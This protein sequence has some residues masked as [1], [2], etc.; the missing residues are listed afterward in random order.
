MGLIWIPGSR[1]QLIRHQARA[2]RSTSNITWAGLVWAHAWLGPENPCNWGLQFL[3]RVPK[4]APRYPNRAT[5]V[6]F[7]RIFLNKQHCMSYKLLY[8]TIYF[9]C[10]KSVSC[11]S[12]SVCLYSI[13]L[14]RGIITWKQMCL[15]CIEGLSLTHSSGWVWVQ[16]K[17]CL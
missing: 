13:H 6:Q 14:H 7:A 8:P 16:N 10:L 5:R 1:V 15:F 4:L 9:L 17:T 2:C 11:H 3:P 12:H